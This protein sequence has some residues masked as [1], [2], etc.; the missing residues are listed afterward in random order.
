VPEADEV[1]R[2]KEMGNQVLNAST[3]QKFN[4]SQITT[5]R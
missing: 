4:R 5:E 3:T 1:K 2:N